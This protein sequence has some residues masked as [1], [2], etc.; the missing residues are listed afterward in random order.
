MGIVGYADHMS[1]QPGDT[2]KF[3]VSSS[4]PRYRA[5]IIRLIHGDANP[6]GPGVKETVV[7]TP[8]QRRLSR[9]ASGAAARLVRD[10]AR[11][12]GASLVAASRSPRGSRRRD[13]IRE[14]PGG[15][16]PNGDQG[17]VTKWSE[18]DKSGYGL[19]IED[20]GRLAVWLGEKGGRVEKVRAETALR[21]WVPSIPGTAKSAPAARDDELVFRRGD[22]RRRE[23]EGD[24]C[25]GAADSISRSI[26][27]ARSPSARPRSRRFATNTAPLLIAAAQ[28]PAAGTHERGR[29]LQRQDRQPARV[30]PGVDP[31]GARRDPGGPRAGRRRRRRGT[32]RSTSR[33]AR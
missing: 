33:P 19:F 10:G 27:R 11:Q 7:E 31:A 32:S 21:P 20:D 24:D 26:R 5:D 6:K 17:I 18:A 13:T 23:R 3:M 4:A 22:L 12:P 30:R 29:P 2:V 14:A 9:Q 16:A 25:A 8:R 28:A 15:T 1:A